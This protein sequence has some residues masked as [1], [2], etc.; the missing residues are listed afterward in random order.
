MELL[1]GSFRPLSIKSRLRDPTLK[2]TLGGGKMDC[3]LEDIEPDDLASR[4]REKSDIMSAG[5]ERHAFGWPRR[6]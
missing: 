1:A 3:G 6:P 4:S 2:P 5:C